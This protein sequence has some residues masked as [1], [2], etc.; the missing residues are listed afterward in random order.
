MREGGSEGEETRGE[1]GRRWLTYGRIFALVLEFGDALLGDVLG[2]HDDDDG[3]GR[4]GHVLPLVGPN[5]GE[6]PQEAL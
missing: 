2:G 3:G 4:G 6:P 1:R 5:R